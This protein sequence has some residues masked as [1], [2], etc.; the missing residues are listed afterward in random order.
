MKVVFLDV[1]GVL[2]STAHLLSLKEMA[3][4]TSEEEGTIFKVSPY[5]VRG[6]PKDVLLHDIR[7]V[8]SKAV[9]LL[10]NLLERSGAKVV[11]SSSWRHLLPLPAMQGILEHHGFKG[12]PLGMTPLQ[13]TP[14]PGCPEA[15]RGHEIQAWLTEHPEID[16]FVILDDDT[17]MVHLED[18]LVRTEFAVGLTAEDVER[19]LVLLST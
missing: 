19:A 7:S 3:P 18:R 12:E 15:L 5:L 8:D 13:V 10:N 9:A 4:A 2:N 1:D 16:R 17:D 6:Y 11:I 14:P